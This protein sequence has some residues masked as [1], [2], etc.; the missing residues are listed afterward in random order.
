MINR[1]S[2]ASSDIRALNNEKV[3]GQKYNPTTK[4]NIGFNI[5]KP[6]ISGESDSQQFEVNS[7]QKR[8]ECRS[9]IYIACY[10]IV[11]KLRGAS[12]LNLDL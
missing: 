9:M 10:R 12:D 5:W 4:R 3:H 1:E 2:I 7:K 6:N 11:H 8:D